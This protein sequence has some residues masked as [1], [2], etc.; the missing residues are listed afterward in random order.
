MQRWIFARLRRALA[1]L[2]PLALVFTLFGRGHVFQSAG[3][4]PCPDDSPAVHAQHQHDDG[5]CNQTHHDCPPDCHRCPCGQIPMV[6]IAPAP[7]LHAALDVIELSLWSPPS[8]RGEAHP[9]RLD[10]PP[11]PTHFS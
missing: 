3:W 6:P 5:D 4:L 11:R 8:T 7:P 9:Q 1:L 10:R 2:V